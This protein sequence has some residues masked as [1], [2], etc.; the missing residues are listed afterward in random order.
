MKFNLESFRYVVLGC[1]LLFS[2][3]LVHSQET[4]KWREDLQFLATELPKRHKNLFHTM[5]R[6]QF[7][8]AIK[9]F[10]RPAMLCKD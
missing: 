10:H 8:K 4:E 1:V 3:L 6:E 2:N 9:I 5:T 7:E